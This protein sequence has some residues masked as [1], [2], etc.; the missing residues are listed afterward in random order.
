MAAIP[1]GL[2]VET[3]WTDEHM[4]EFWISAANESF[5]GAATCYVALDEANRLAAAIAGFPRS[6]TDVREY[7]FGDP[8]GFGMGAAHLHFQCT[9]GFG[10][11]AVTVKLWSAPNGNGTESVSLVLRTVPA[12]I[13]S[14]VSQLRSM[15]RVEGDKAY[16]HHAI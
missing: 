1:L 13:D 11:L 9:H 3:V 16:L 8:S 4:L 15:R 2:T 6:T 5:S 10:H 12:Q 7:R 14:F